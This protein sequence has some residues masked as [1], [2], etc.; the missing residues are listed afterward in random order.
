MK[1]QT[2]YNSSATS[3]R[4]GKAETYVAFPRWRL[5]RMMGLAVLSI[6]CFILIGCSGQRDASQMPD[7]QERE[8][9][10][11]DLPSPSD[12]MDYDPWESINDKTFYFNFNLADH[13]A[14]KPAAKVWSRLPEQFRQSLANAF[15]NL[16]MPKRFVNKVLQGRLPSA[17]L[18][19]ARFVVNTTVG[20]AG[21]FDVASRLHIEKTDADTGETF[22]LY[23]VGPGPYL[24]V[25]LLPPLDVRDA[26]GFA[27]DSFM[28][29]LSWFITPIGADFGR[30][31]VK[32][33]NER[34]NNMQL[35]DDVEDS[36]LDLYAAVRNGYLQR[37]RKFI[38]DAI[39][40]RDRAWGRI[41][42]PSEPEYQSPLEENP[43][44]TE[45]QSENDDFETSTK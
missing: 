21:L 26:F 11:S 39:R 18:E 5:V 13:Y 23:G 32:Q 40:D 28:D 42:H 10:A 2:L 36:S 38:E 8:A 9:L 4:R 6:A 16:D 44:S 27:A 14:I 25:P 34:A 15:Y 33:I 30:S 45:Q 12:G 41:S 22:A 29:P 3:L 1:F 37:R 31:A 24:V 19:L 17:G 43:K 35:Y 20:V 7:V